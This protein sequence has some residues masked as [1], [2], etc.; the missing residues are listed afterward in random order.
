MVINYALIGLSIVF[1]AWV[2]QFFTMNKRRE[3]ST[4]FIITY[5]L[6][7]IFLIFDGYKAGQIE[8][9]IING[10]VVLATICVLIKFSKPQH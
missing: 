6:G 1:I 10:L 4:S 2:I 7:V 3:I 5:M 9:A 8:G